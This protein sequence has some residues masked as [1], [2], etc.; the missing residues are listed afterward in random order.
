VCGPAG[1]GAGFG[2]A[3]GAGSGAGFGFASARAGCS[4]GCDGAPPGFPREDHDGRSYTAS[5]PAL[6]VRS[7]PPGI[8]R[9]V[10]G[11]DAD[12]SP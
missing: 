7:P 3:A 5:P 8:E 10:P 6:V 4:F 12:F 11:V 1:S 2:F 9:V